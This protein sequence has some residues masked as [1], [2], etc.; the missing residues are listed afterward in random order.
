MAYAFQTYDLDKRNNVKRDQESACRK[1]LLSFLTDFRFCG[2]YEGTS[3]TG[4]W[5]HEPGSQC[6]I[7]DLLPYVFHL[8]I[9]KS[10]LCNKNFIILYLIN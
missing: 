10:A 6:R 9:M 4:S 1:R 3:F 8:V 7:T 2:N 5:G